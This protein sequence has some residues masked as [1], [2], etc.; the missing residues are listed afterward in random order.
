MIAM[1]VDNL[2]TLLG[3]AGVVEETQTI[4]PHD[5]RFLFLTSSVAN[6]PLKPKSRSYGKR[7]ARRFLI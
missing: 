7:F 6:E 3:K 1:P 5:G 2:S 4:F